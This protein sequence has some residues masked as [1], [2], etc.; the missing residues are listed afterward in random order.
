M[1]TLNGKSAPEDT[2]VYCWRSFVFMSFFVSQCQE[3]AFTHSEETWIQV[4]TK[5]QQLTG[6]KISISSRLKN[7]HDCNFKNTKN[8]SE[9]LLDYCRL[10][11]SVFMKYPFFLYTLKFNAVL[12]TPTCEARSFS[13]P[14]T[15]P[16]ASNIIDKGVCRWY[17]TGCIIIL[18]DFAHRLCLLIK[19]AKFLKLVL[20]PCSEDRWQK[21][22]PSAFGS[23][24]TPSRKLRLCT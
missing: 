1:K 3:R 8:C 19:T 6:H 2:T 17:N 13:L 20:F 11:W 4:Q 22:K 10:V 7:K 14:A 15:L 5:H 16:V 12:F 23:L 18:Y 24:G 21:R 9:T